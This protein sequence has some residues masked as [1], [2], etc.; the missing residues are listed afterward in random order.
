MTKN[1]KKYLI[2][3]TLRNVFLVLLYFTGCIGLL[4]I[5]TY[6]FSISVIAFSIV[7]GA[8]LL[9]TALLLAYDEAKD[10]YCEQL[11]REMEW[12]DERRI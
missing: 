2:K 8:I 9:G 7:L 11:L 5:L 10:S 1:Y 3:R 4:V 12:N 6:L